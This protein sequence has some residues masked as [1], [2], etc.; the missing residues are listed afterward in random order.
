MLLEIAHELNRDILIWK[1][2]RYLARPALSKHD[3]PIGRFRVWSRQFYQAQGLQV[4]TS[5]PTHSVETREACSLSQ[6]YL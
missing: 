1:Q 6:E 5:T 2:K 4:H 3:G